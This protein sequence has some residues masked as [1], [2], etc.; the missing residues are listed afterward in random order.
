MKLSILDAY[1]LGMAA[2][3]LSK[4]A[5]TASLGTKEEVEHIPIEVSCLISEAQRKMDSVSISLRGGKFKIP[6]ELSELSRTTHK[7]FRHGDSLSDSLIHD[8]ISSGEADR[9]WVAFLE[10][11]K[12]SR[13]RK[14]EG[15]LTYSRNSFS[16]YLRRSIELMEDLTFKEKVL[17]A[18]LCSIDD[19]IVFSMV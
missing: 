11:I 2:S 10:M 15:R 6:D 1:N 19:E 5:A 4:A 3:A 7:L 14:D 16:R 8:I 13:P 12:K 18:M 9:V 17:A